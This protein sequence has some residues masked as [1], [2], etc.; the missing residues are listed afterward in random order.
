[1]TGR[2]LPVQAERAADPGA[3]H[4]Q[5]GLPAPGLQGQVPPGLPHPAQDDLLEVLDQLLA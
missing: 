3:E 5:G 2:L 1:M 4:P